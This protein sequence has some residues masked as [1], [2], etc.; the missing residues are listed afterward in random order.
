[1]L[2]VKKTHES[3]RPAPRSFTS[4]STR[5]RNHARARL[6]SVQH[7]AAPAFSSWINPASINTLRCCETVDCASGVCSTTS[8]TAHSGH[9]ERYW[10]ILNLT[11]L[12]SASSILTRRRSCLSRSIFF[13]MFLSQPGVLLSFPNMYQHTLY[14]VNIRYEHRI[15][16]SYFFP[17]TLNPGDPLPSARLSARYPAR[18][19]A[20]F[21][22]PP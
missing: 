6:S 21:S 3:P 17:F 1:M 4:L 13:T 19:P 8:W 5:S 16:K 14:I 10:S 7:L 22:A 20:P 9:R 18:Y 2:L 15:V 11:G 12:P